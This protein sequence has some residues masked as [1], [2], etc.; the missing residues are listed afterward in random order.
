MEST[1][2]SE[3]GSQ[4]KYYLKEF[5]FLQGGEAAP[6]TPLINLSSNRWNQISSVQAVLYIEFEVDYL[7]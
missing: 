4:V 5:R 3:E 7:T 2:T 6:V 1:W